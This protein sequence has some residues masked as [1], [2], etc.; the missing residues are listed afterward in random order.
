[1]WGQC[2]HQLVEASRGQVSTFPAAPRGIRGRKHE[3]LAATE[4]P[5]LAFEQR[6]RMRGEAGFLAPPTA[7]SLSWC[8]RNTKT[9]YTFFSF[10][11][12]S[13]KI[14]V[15]QSFC[16]RAVEWEFKSNLI[17]PLFSDFIRFF[18]WFFS[19]FFLPIFRLFLTF[20]L[21][22]ST[23]LVQ[24]LVFMLVFNLEINNRKRCLAHFLGIDVI[25]QFY[26]YGRHSIMGTIKP[27]F[28]LNLSYQGAQRL[29]ER[30]NEVRSCV[31]Q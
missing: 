20:R 5:Q 24:I 7:A 23:A 29:G 9:G 3:I 1:M 8:L 16:F 27:W 15:E 14:W 6:L 17:L 12:Q 2:C 26:F 10:S 11:V 21:A 22:D 28:G 13:V 18:I 19:V 31:R 4:Y 30:K 25:K